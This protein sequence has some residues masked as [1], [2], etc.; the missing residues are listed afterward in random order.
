MPAVCL[1]VAIRLAYQWK[2]KRFYFFV[3]LYVYPNDL[4]TV[5]VILTIISFYNAVGNFKQKKS[6][7]EN[8]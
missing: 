1:S 3:S 7:P 5:C 8:I 4:L 2:K 6:I